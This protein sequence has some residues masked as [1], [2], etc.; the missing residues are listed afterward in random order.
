MDEQAVCGLLGLAMRAGQLMVGTGRCMD[1]IRRGDNVLVLV[2]ESASDNTRKRITD[3]SAHHGQSFFTVPSG[4]LESALGRSGIMVAGLSE[5]GLRDK[6][7]A[8]ITANND[9]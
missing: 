4:L 3:G 5:G 8:L 7:A 2:D 1:A 9:R 6:I